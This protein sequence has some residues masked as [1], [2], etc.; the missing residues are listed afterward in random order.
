MKNRTPIF[1]T[2]EYP[3][4]LFDSY[5]LICDGFIQ[6]ILRKDQNEIFNFSGLHTVKAQNEI[7]IRNINIPKYQSVVLLYPDH[8]L[9]ESEAVL[10]ILR[11]IGTS[12][13]F[14]RML[15]A[16][17][18]NWRNR[19]YRWIAQNRYRFF[20]KRDHCPLPDPGVA[21]RFI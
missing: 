3:V 6:W 20:K 12:P 16:I 10:D 17:P 4:I 7:A 9:I 11:L 21:S 19:V 5:C 15:T 18:S 2:K 14:M 1:K 13:F 8:D